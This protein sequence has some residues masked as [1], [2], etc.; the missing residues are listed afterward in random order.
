MKKILTSLLFALPM[1][2]QAQMLQLSYD[3]DYPNWKS[4]HD[5]FSLFNN[6]FKDDLVKGFTPLQGTPGFSA[7]VGWGKVSYMVLG[8]TQ[9]NSKSTAEFFTGFKKEASVSTQGWFLELGAGA[10]PI[11]RNR[12]MIVPLAGMSRRT[13]YLRLGTRYPNGKLSYSWNDRDNQNFGPVYANDGEYFMKFIP[14]FYAGAQL[15][16]PITKHIHAFAKYSY[17]LNLASQSAYQSVSGPQDPLGDGYIYGY[18][19][20]QSKKNKFI[21]TVS[22]GNLVPATLQIGIVLNKADM[23]K[24]YKSKKTKKN[25]E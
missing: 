16:L 1:A 23:R 4:L 24:E 19:V 2:M 13:G 8:Y 25:E 15:R 22:G 12:L 5:Y 7:S 10:F 18:A 20:D 21:S 11:I 17:S 3:S 14:L 9:A 6:Q